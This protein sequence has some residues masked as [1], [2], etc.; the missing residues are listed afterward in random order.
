MDTRGKHPNSLKN[1][2]PA[3]PGEIRNP[4]GSVK[5]EWH[6]GKLLT[7]AIRD[8]LDEEVEVTDKEG[9]PVTDEK[10]NQVFITRGAQLVRRV[11][12]Q[13]ISKGDTQMLKIVWNYLDGMPPEFVDITTDGSPITKDI[14]DIIRKAYG[15]GTVGTTGKDSS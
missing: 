15:K 1:L 12:L 2:K 9:K 14:D 7:K 3:K 13:S 10:G 11:L 6:R 5:G 8:A 4:K